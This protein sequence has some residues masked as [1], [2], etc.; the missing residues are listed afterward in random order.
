MVKMKYLEILFLTVV[1]SSLISCQTISAPAPLALNDKS[2]GIAIAVFIKEF[3]E[4]RQ[5]EKVYFV[6]MD[7]NADENFLFTRTNIIQTNFIRGNYIYLLNAEPGDYAAV[8]GHYGPKSSTARTSSSG[9]TITTGSGSASSTK[10][11]EDKS[12]RIVYFPKEMIKSTRVT[13][14]PGM[15]A[16]MGEYQVRTKQLKKPDDAQMHYYKVIEP[17]KRGKTSFKDIGLRNFV[18]GALSGPENVTYSQQ[19]EVTGVVRN[20]NS[21][22]R[23]LKTAEYDL[24]G[25]GWSDRI[26]NQWID[27][28]AGKPGSSFQSNPK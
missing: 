8:G 1:S 7:Q 23:F 10:K 15:M 24:K 20:K 16:F 26:Q 4:T 17:E 18:L 2:S 13:V 22:A 11:D 6:K 28:V 25:G 19:G 27:L 21:E 14:T 9:W 5:P 3:G 12:T